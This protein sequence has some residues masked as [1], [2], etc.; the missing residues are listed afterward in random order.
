MSTG[1]ARGRAVCACDVVW[2]LK[3]SG[4]LEHMSECHVGKAS[5]KI[6]LKLEL[7]PPGHRTGQR[8][9]P[10]QICALKDVGGH[11]VGRRDVVDPQ[12]G[13]RHPPRR[14]RGVPPR[15][16]RQIR[17]RPYSTRPRPSPQDSNLWPRV[18]WL[19]AVEPWTPARHRPLETMLNRGYV[20][21]SF[22][23]NSYSLNLAPTPVFMPNGN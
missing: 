18:A 9:P 21:T 8:T 2:V 23:P 6:G 4:A 15:M 13:H 1:P 11:N 3:G 19:S 12:R 22:E 17:A 20:K 7:L 16:T 10:P 14:A 5:Q